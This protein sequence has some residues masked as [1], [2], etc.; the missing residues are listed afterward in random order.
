MGE[1][2]EYMVR[3][4]VE[5]LEELWASTGISDCKLRD[6]LYANIFKVEIFVKRP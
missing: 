1:R 3:E 6:L 4:A 5:K 2:V